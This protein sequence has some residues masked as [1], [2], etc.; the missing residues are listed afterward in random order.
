MTY[1]IF[2]LLEWCAFAL[3]LTCLILKANSSHV[4]G[5]LF[6]LVSFA[7]PT[8]PPH[9]RASPPAFKHALMFLTEKAMWKTN[10]FPLFHFSSNTIQSV[11][12]QKKVS[13]KKKDFIYLFLD[14]GRQGER[15][16]EKH[17]CVAASHMPLHWGPG[18]Q[19][20]HVPWLGI[21]PVGHPFICRPVLIPLSHTSHCQK[22]TS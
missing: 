19:P 20:R 12:L 8:S 7:C 13:L 17:Q 2:V 18:L 1:L 21:E 16:R 14:R 9:S 10:T 11:Y 3:V 5:V 15:E 4:L 22:Q 6:L